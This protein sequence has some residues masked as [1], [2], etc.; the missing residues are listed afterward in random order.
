MMTVHKLTAG[1]GYTYLTRQ[2]AANDA[3]NIEQS[4]LGAYYSERGES[5]GLWLGRGLSGL[6]D[7]PG[8]GERVE[9]AQMIALFGYG[10]H[11]NSEA[12]SQRAVA[13]GVT[14]VH[15]RAQTRLGTPFTARSDS[16][17]FTRELARRIAGSNV[18][19]D[20]PASTRVDGETRARLRSEL[21][22]EWFRRDH[23]RAPA[24][25]R[26][27]S[28][29][30]TAAARPGSS[31][32][33]G[34]DLTF[35]PVKSVSALWA[36]A[37]AEMAAQIEAA[38]EAATR[39]VIA[40]L[41][42]TS[43][44]TRLGGNGVR[45]VDVR[46]LLAVA[47]THRDSRD[48]D[49]DLH[50]HV[51]ISNKVQTLDGRWRALDGRV[52]YKASVSAS[53]RYN[54]RLEAHL[55]ARL[56]VRFAERT[57]G[58]E[59]KRPVREILGMDPELLT[60]WSTRRRSIRARHADLSTDFVRRHGRQ[61]GVGETHALYD[62]AN[63]STRRAKHAPR[64]R[65][66][67]RTAWWQQA[68]HLLGGD[69]AVVEMITGVSPRPT[70][71]EHRVTPSGTRSVEALSP[72]VAGVAPTWPRDAADRAVA[73]VARS[74][75]TWQTHHVRAE[76]ERI[77]RTDAVPLEDLDLAVDSAVEVALSPAV[78]IRLGDD[79]DRLVEPAALRR[80][81]GSSV[82]T[83]A[84]AQLFTS[85]KVIDAEARVLAAAGGVG[86][87]RVSDG[88]VELNLLEARARELPLTEAQQQLV[89]DLATS[90]LRVQL[91]LAPAGSGKTTAL[92]ILARAWCEGGG[93]VI[94]LAPSASAAAELRAALDAPTDTVA[95][96]LHSL[97]APTRPAWV[98]TIGPATL[99]VLD[100]AGT[101]CTADLDRTITH[102]LSRGASIR[103]IGDT[104]Q[105]AAPE[106]GGLLR[107]LE[108]TYGAATLDSLVRFTDE[109]EGS[110]SLAL[111]VGDPLALGY[112]LD[113]DRVHSGNATGIA[114]QAIAAWSVD[115][116]AGRSSI[117]L[118][119]TNETVRDLNER[120]SALHPATGP[121]VTLGDGLA[122]GAGDLIVTRH[123]DRRLPLTSTDWVKNG[124]R[125]LVESVGSDGSVQARHL[126]TR[127]TVSLPAGYVRRHV[128][129][130]YATTVHLAQGHTADT[131]HTVLSGRES[132]ELLY[133]A[134]TRGREGNHVYLDAGAP[135][136]PHEATTP[137]AVAPPTS[138]EM[139]ERILA[140]EATRPSAT[141]QRHQ[142]E[143]P[144]HRLRIAAERYSEAVATCST[145]PGGGA[146]PLP[147]LSP[148]PDVDGELGDY[149]A[150]RH[151]LVVDTAA[152]LTSEDLAFGMWSRQ[153][154]DDK[155]ELAR[156]LAVWRAAAGCATDPS[157]TGPADCC[158]PDY[159]RELNARVTAV[160]GQQPVDKWAPVVTAIEP[161]L[162]ASR[163]WVGLAADLDRAARSGFDVAAELP[164]LIN[165][166][167]L[168][169]SHVAQAVSFRLAAA[170][171]AAVEPRRPSEYPVSSKV[172]KSGDTR[173]ERNR[174]AVRAA[175]A[176]GGPARH[177]QEVKKPTPEPV[178]RPFAP[179]PTR[180]GPAR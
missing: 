154:K 153:L 104:R 122:G 160:I 69:D 76:I 13:A 63:T 145:E 3:T 8:L 176:L 82:F 55:S 161:R 97:D 158:A 21:G 157:P 95:K 144:A 22:V 15:A 9:E 108:R 51:A 48:G 80:R 42:K 34:Y 37:P 141:S 134:M 36:L 6:G 58:R 152:R 171:P 126:A 74:R 30:V 12:V 114:E 43:V 130:G 109:V 125:W 70:Q 4:S 44:Y 146:R 72:A 84:G 140:R 60:L 174:Q 106:S 52:L 59:G 85:Q 1:H 179:T 138:V 32:V 116:A 61:P 89:R 77:A 117:L 111:R 71:P 164:V 11:P 103:L 101:A 121:T 177:A 45:Q 150:Q 151:A 124:D 148:M 25:A 94:G 65:S 40:W 31:S 178:P 33:A 88:I 133:V 167:P 17:G 173:A 29:Y 26:E 100:E 162:V 156:E 113:H 64:S 170:C 137:D 165:Q 110:A 87:R 129:L 159:R 131:C 35:S 169:D 168:P 155:P 5:P 92:G 67:Q 66:E 96:L 62:L 38:H 2:V 99:V 127:R 180:G 10:R 79:T 143:D 128:E 68:G 102:V 49:P 105:L 18:E 112:Y 118:A 123:N 28:D 93:E 107:D 20:R 98:D 57:S 27:L 142:T 119:A 86:G 149:L 90:G 7:G 23:G 16:R 56:G 166:R 120:A 172:T 75:A 135:A 81:D 175:R 83:V 78:S 139:L 132:R 91:A 47:F 136:D 115:L 41:E 73:V 19:R 53:E 50:T 24:D 14:A 147:W 54:T 163:G 46:G 39:D